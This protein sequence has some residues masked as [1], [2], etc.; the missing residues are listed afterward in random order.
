MIVLLPGVHLRMLSRLAGLSLN[1]TRYHIHNLEKD[2]EIH[3][4]KEGGYLRAYPSWVKDERTMKVYALL[5]QKAARKVL[6]ALS[7]QGRTDGPPMT[8]GAISDSTGLSKSTVS[9]YLTLFRDLQIARRTTSVEGRVIFELEEHDVD[10]TLSIL[11]SLDR[12]LLAR[13]TDS[14]LDLWEM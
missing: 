9:E 1:T 10:H 12:S 11:E 6:L 13:A 4:Q 8:N 5:Q 3:C 14:Y 2:G 7:S